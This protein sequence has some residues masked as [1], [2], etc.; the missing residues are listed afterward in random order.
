MGAFGWASALG[1]GAGAMYFLDEAT[2]R[3]RRARLREKG[4]HVLRRAGADLS[5]ASRDLAHRT[6]GLFAEARYRLRSGDADDV[7]LSA[8]ARSRLGHVCSH[9]HAICVDVHEG[10]VMLT[11][12]VL[13]REHARVVRELSKVPGVRGVE[14]RLQVHADARGVPSLQGEREAST[15]Q[16]TW[17]PGTRL[18][19]G[20]AGAAF[21]GV[22]VLAR[23][24]VRWTLGGIGLGVL[25]V[26]IARPS[27]L[28]REGRFAFQ[29]TLRVEAPVEEVFEFWRRFENFPRFMAH[30][31]RVRDLGSGRSEWTVAGPGGV[32]VTWFA[33]I[34]EH[35]PNVLLRWHTEPGSTLSHRGLVRFEDVGEGSTRLDVLFE[36][37]PPAGALGWAV[38][39][40]LGAD[41]KRAMDEDL[42]RLKSLLERGRTRLHGQSVS[43]EELT[44]H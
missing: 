16:R 13:E 2:G 33:A 14:D 41:P 35:R 20:I 40:L 22:S 4:G 26:A 11:G 25:S 43:R 27:H 28:R 23:G 10:V 29:K 3:T 34:D 1:I 17:A 21:V 19:A 7:T 42:V 5:T 12:D 32:P 31:R 36:Y 24:A 39:R 8:R 18:A 38:A 9:P 37:E 44:M 30:V 15:L 6:G